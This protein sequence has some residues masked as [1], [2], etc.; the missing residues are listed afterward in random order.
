MLP[1]GTSREDVVRG[2]S[3][4]TDM[5]LA[6][7]RTLLLPGNIWNRIIENTNG[8]FSRVVV[9]EDMPLCWNDWFLWLWFRNGDQ[10]EVLVSII[11]ASTWN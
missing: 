9:N 7:A 11:S 4:N 3:W 6:A 8:V 10:L 5:M 2:L 1:A